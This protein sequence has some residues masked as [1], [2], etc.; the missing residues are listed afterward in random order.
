MST[1]TEEGISSGRGVHPAVYLARAYLESQRA[2]WSMW[3][4]ALAGMDTPGG[5][6]YQA[7]LTALQGT[8]PVSV[9]D[10]LGLAW[11]MHTSSHALGQ[12]APHQDDGP[13]NVL[14][15]P[16]VSDV[17]TTLTDA[18]DMGL[19]DVIVVGYDNEDDLVL[20]S[21]GMAHK[22]ALWMLVQAQKVVLE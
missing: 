10:V 5:A 2:Y 4:E 12:K 17:R 18:A 7:T 15:F 11:L 8:E 22:D 9:E 13:S 20:L 19:S 21:S 1:P 14:Q 16:G 6:R 3:L